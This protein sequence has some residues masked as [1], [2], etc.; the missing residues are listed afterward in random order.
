MVLDPEGPVVEVQVLESADPS[1]QWSRLDDFKGLGYER[2]LVTVTTDDG[3]VEA[4]LYVHL[5]GRG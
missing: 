5:P 3:A 1:A 2:V 4:S